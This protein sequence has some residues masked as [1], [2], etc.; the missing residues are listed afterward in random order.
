MYK[1]EPEKKQIS[2]SEIF[3]YSNIGSWNNEKPDASITGRI[4]RKTDKFIE[5]Q[6]D[7]GYIQM[8]ELDKVF[9]VVYK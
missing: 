5:I 7:G 8:I 4:A 1:A 9:A 3:I 2:R 6:D